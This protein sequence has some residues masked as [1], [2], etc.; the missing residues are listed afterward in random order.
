MFDLTRLDQNLRS[1]VSEILRKL[2]NLDLRLKKIEKE[3]EKIRVSDG[4][5]A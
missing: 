1:V 4:K 2:D 5:R 3:I